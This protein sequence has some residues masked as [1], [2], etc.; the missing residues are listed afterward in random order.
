MQIGDRLP[1][2]LLEFGRG[3]LE[4]SKRVVQFACVVVQPSLHE[5]RQR[6]RGIDLASKQGMLPSSGRI[7]PR[8]GNPCEQFV[9]GRAQSPVL[10]GRAERKHRLLPRFVQ[11]PEP[12]ERPGGIQVR[13]REVR[14]ERGRAS[15]RVGGPIHATGGG[16]GVA[17]LLPRGR[18]ERMAPR[19]SLQHQNRFRH[20]AGAHPHGGVTQ[21]LYDLDLLVPVGRCDRIGIH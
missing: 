10:A 11:P 15:I 19:Q 3:P 5:R 17:Q 14:T 6:R 21:G 18:D 16:R 1:A 4:R 9:S 20:L 7:A 13:G 12:E 2:R 8:E